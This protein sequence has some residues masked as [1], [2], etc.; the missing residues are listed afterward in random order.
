M[1]YVPWLEG[2]ALV[3]CDLLDHHS[4]EAVTHSPRA[5]LKQQV[6]RLE[7]M[8]MKAFMASELEFFLF[9]DS[10]EGAQEKAYRNLKNHQCL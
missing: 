3:L 1:R 2:T 7:A 9:D 8:G 5:I 4:H 6:A 10:F